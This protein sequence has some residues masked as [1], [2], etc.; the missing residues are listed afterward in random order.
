MTAV[1][2]PSFTDLG[3]VAPAESAI[4]AGTLADINAAFGGALNPDLV[5]PQGQL[6]SSLAAIV[7]DANNQF[8]ALANG[9]DPAF[10]SGRMQDAIGRI[11]FLDRIPAASTVAQIVC[12]GAV[13]VA[14]PVGASLVAADGNYYLCTFA[15]TIPSG[16]S[17]VLP[18]SCRVTGPIACPAQTFTIYQTVPG[19]DAATSPADGVLGNDVE[20]RG[21]FETR[22]AL[23]VAANGNG[24]TAA[25]RGAVLA[26]SGVID[27][28]VIDNPTDGA[29]TIGGVTLAAN[30]IY[31]A[32]FGGGSAAVAK[33]IWTKKPPG[34][35]YNGSTTVTVYDDNAGYTTPPAYSVSYQIPSAVT[36]KFAITLA[37]VPLVPSNAAALVQAAI[38]SAFSGGDG[39]PRATIGSTIYASRFYSA[40]AALG[41][42]VRIVSIKLGTSTATL[43]DVTVDIDQI[44]STS[45]GNITVTLI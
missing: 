19:W 32:A 11:Y 5:S 39:G 27:A 37:S 31:V 7:G 29:V 3:F 44:P 1:P 42:W 28:Y 26:V 22:R 33:A 8:C 43:D 25:I 16:G 45:A 2:T 13:G 6:A 36:I 35:A 41:S 10:A 40:V 12:S 17:I 9:V 23:S 18:F 30:S 21:A 15:G 24:T 20:S 4:I 34:C 38:L 14:I